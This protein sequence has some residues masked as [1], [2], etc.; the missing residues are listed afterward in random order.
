V[1]GSVSIVKKAGLFLRKHYVFLL[2]F[3]LPSV[4]LE[5]AYAC[6]F[7]YPFG[8]CD[9]LIIDLFHQYA[10]FISD[11][12]DKLKSFSS[13]LYSWSGGLGASYLPQ[14]AYYLASP[15]NLL[16]VLFPKEYLS[17][18]I[19]FLTLLKV[20]L[21][22]ACFAYYL[23]G[24]HGEENLS[25]VAFSLLYA[26]SGFVLAYCWNIM[27]MD[28]IYLLPLVILGLVKI[29]RGERGIFYCLTLAL[30][31]I[32]NFYM[33]F[34]ICMFI[35]L[36]YPVCLFQYC[37]IKPFGQIVRKTAR[38]ASFSLLAGGLSAFLLLPTFFALRL[39]SAADDVFPKT[40]KQFYD[41][42][43]YLTRHFTMASPAIREGMPNIYCGII[44]LILVPVYFFLSSISTKEKLLNIAII[45]V[46]I[47]SF[48]INMLNFIWHGFHYPNQLPHRFAFVYV[49][50][51]LSISY[52]AYARINEISRR[53]IGAFCFTV[54]VLI[55]MTQKFTDISIQVYSLYAGMF[56]V[57]LYA[58][59]LTMKKAAAKR[60][61][62][63][64]LVVIFEVTANTIVNVIEINMT[65]GYTLRNGY[66]SGEE[67]SQLREQ[68]SM[69]SRENRE[70]FRME[71]FPPK[72]ANDPHLY[73]Y[74]GLSIFSST[75]PE[76]PVKMMDNFG[77]HTNGINS[78]KYEG[79]T[80]LLDSIF[81]IKYLINRSQNIEEVIYKEIDSTN[82]ITVFENPYAISIGFWAPLS[83]KQYTSK[84]SNPFDG[85][86][87][88]MKHL[89]KIENVFS[90]LEMV[91]AQHS[92]L[93]FS[94]TS[95]RYYNFTRP[96]QDAKST[97]KVRIFVKED[98]QVYLY[99][100]T[101]PN[102]ID[103][104]FIMIGEKKI[105]F[106]A[107]RSTLINPG[108]YRAGTVLELNLVFDESAPASG[109]F[110]LY[111][112]SLNL[113][114]FEKAMEILGKSAF[115]IESFDNTRIKGIIKSEE[116]GLL[117]M[118]I[119][120]DKGWHVK[121]DGREVETQAFDDGLLSIEISEGKHDVELWYVPEYFLIGLMVTLAS[122]LI[123][124]LAAIGNKI[125]KN[126]KAQCK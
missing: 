122:I 18:A 124:V 123:L 30:A 48:D 35:A 67:V 106:N 95:T 4:I 40:F 77:Y 64:L 21:A 36:Y 100:D 1:T 54:L 57:I 38:F 47:M 80:V 93:T 27:W 108:F 102:V 61:L 118:T 112:Y 37:G 59:A 92:N 9:V 121:V 72:T 7:I 114:E 55:V 12:Q 91:Q 66:S 24:V 28:A 5:I 42:F 94:S 33:A 6:N 125:F 82:E 105:D 51:I 65:E 81:G 11:L 110:Q 75:F 52:K 56:F 63:F 113:P 43:D 62:I 99:L 109:N 107:S 19:L 76:K 90:P 50:L 74:R 41:L 69:L 49:F 26:L 3:F 68:I 120:Y 45:F 71:V 87:A 20:G 46:L 22:G 104:G 34:F 97:A 16:T 44:V 58:A 83:M 39:T 115:E 53:Q 17:E 8:N 31:I 103:N 60:V 23:K 111:A 84:W 78:Y 126:K 79:S 88:L 89:V 116:N 14:I 13:L 85:Q 86:N 32:S 25:T 2:S 15:F 29:V 119:P 98:Q 101:S 96:N 70:F 10:P 73:N 117:I